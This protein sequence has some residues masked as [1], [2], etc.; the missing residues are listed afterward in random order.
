MQYIVEKRGHRILPLIA[1]VIATAFLVLLAGN[2]SA[3]PTG[4]FEIDVFATDVDGNPV[5]CAP[6]STECPKKSYYSGN[7]DLD[8]GDGKADDWA[9]GAFNNGVFLPSASAPHTATPLGPCYGSN[10]DLNPAITYTSR[11]ICD[12]FTGISGAPERSIVSPAG[13]IP[14]DVWQI[15]TSNNL[16]PKDDLSHGYFVQLTQDCS[17]TPHNIVVVG[18]E[19]GNNEGANHWGIELN[20]VAPTGLQTVAD[21]LSPAA[22]FALNFNRVVGDVFVSVDLEKG[23][24]EP[25]ILVTQVSGFLA[26]DDATFVAASATGECVGQFAAATTSTNLLEQLTPPWNTPVCDTTEADDAPNSCRIANGLGTGP[27]DQGPSS[28]TLPDIPKKDNTKI[29]CTTLPKR[30]FVE[31]AIDLT[32]YNVARGCFADVLLTTRSAPPGTNTLPVVDLGGADIKDVSAAV[33]PPC[34]ISWEKRDQSQGS[35]GSHPLQGGATFTISPNPDACDDPN[36][37]GPDDDSPL[38]VLDDISASDSPDVVPDADDDAGQFSLPDVC[39]GNYT[40]TE[41]AAPSGFARDTDTTRGCNVSVVAPSCVV[42]TALT[43][44]PSTDDEGTRDG[45]GQCTDNECDFHNRRGSVAWEKRDG[46]LLTGDPPAHPLQPGA[47]FTVAPDPDDCTDGTVGDDPGPITVVDGG[48]NDDGDGSD[49]VFAVGPACAATYTITETVAPPG[50]ALP[51]NPVRTCEVTTV[52]LSCV[53]GT[54]GTDDCANATADFCNRLGSLEWEKRSDIDGHLQGEATFTVDGAVANQPGGV[55]GEDGPF[56]CHTAVDVD[57]VTVVDNSAPDVDTDLGQLR[58]ENVCLG[59]YTI[60]ETDAKDGFAIDPNP[61]RVCT[62]TAVALS[63]VIGSPLL[64]PPAPGELPTGNDDCPDGGDA[65]TNGSDFCNL[66]GS[67]YWEKRG[68]DASTLET[69][70]ELLPGFGFT[71]TGKGEIADCTIGP[72]AAGGDQNADKGKFC[73]DQMPIGV[74]L[75]IDETSKA[76]GYIQTVPVNDGDLTKTLLTSSKCSGGASTANDAG[77]FINQ[78]LSKFKIDFICVAFSPNDLTEPRDCATKAKITCPTPA[79][80]PTPDD[81]TPTAFD[82]ISETYGNATSTLLEGLY[83]CEIDID[84]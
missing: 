29:A 16:T 65:D 56:A 30:D 25:G 38:T 72:C 39:P 10:V 4:P 57:P 27:V 58:L 73:L 32:A 37:T 63:C 79:I 45:S 8:G 2:V 20:A 54:Q 14:Q 36:P 3:V 17:G 74:L 19:R 55:A 46:A 31:I 82:D 47:T 64:P 83:K 44:P 13:D 22:D 5:P 81:L 28:C 62:V 66:V 84:P 80:T 78:P 49:G 70:D 51:A 23:G 76:T 75:T 59:S 35:A 77:D 12:G 26:N 11:F 34:A 61:T 33:L 52:A 21:G 71:V 18:M 40:I 41:S 15:T 1:L 48:A 43:A 7:G 24:D 60:T 42:G 69:G 68:K 67:L 6:A 50:Y 53:V 9:Q